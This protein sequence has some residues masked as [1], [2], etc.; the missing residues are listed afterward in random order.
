MSVYCSIIRGDESGF[1]VCS[2]LSRANF[3]C[4]SLFRAVP[5]FFT[6]S[7]VGL[8]IGFTLNISPKT[9]LV[10]DSLPPAARYL[11]LSRNIYSSLISTAF[12]AYLMTESKSSDFIAYLAV[13][14]TIIPRRPAATPVSITVSR[15]SGSFFF[16]HPLTIS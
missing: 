10:L 14:I 3:S 13:A 1:R 9:A 16:F 5:T 11:S 12:F 6:P 15:L 2:I 8:T 7:D 4:P